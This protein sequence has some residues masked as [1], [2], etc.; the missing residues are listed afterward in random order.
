MIYGD[1]AMLTVMMEGITEAKNSANKHL[2]E[3]ATRLWLLRIY[4]DDEFVEMTNHSLIESLME[5]YC[6]ELNKVSLEVLKIIGPD[7]V[8]CGSPFAD[9]DG[10]GI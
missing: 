8:V 4:R 6:E 2:L 5:E 3:V 9:P 1:I 10:K 7:D